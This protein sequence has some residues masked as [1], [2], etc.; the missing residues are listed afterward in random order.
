MLNFLEDDESR[1]FPGVYFVPSVDLG[2]VHSDN[3]GRG[4][5]IG[6][7]GNPQRQ[8]VF[9]Q[10]SPAYAV[11]P[12]I[13]NQEDM[14]PLWSAPLLTLQSDSQITHD[15]LAHITECW[16]GC[17]TPQTH[18]IHIDLSLNHSLG[19]ELSFLDLQSL[20]EGA[21]SLELWHSVSTM[22]SMSVALCTSF[23][24]HTIK[25]SHSSS[26]HHTNRNKSLLLVRQVRYS[27][28][29]TKYCFIEMFAN[30][31]KKTIKC[32]C[33]FCVLFRNWWLL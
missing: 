17:L 20:R 11:P 16:C 30:I 4:K 22:V 10:V 33:V 24:M 12:Q 18:P 29:R 27:I 25:D 28:F 19:H 13:E 2:K 14:T 26:A 31:I 32:L 1:Y 21:A 7:S 3:W 6:Q 8:P 23:T 9:H 5:Q 15:L